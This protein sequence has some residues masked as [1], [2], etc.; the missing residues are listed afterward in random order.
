[1][2][3]EDV[4]GDLSGVYLKRGDFDNGDLSFTIASVD[5]VT[6]EARNGKPPEQKWALT[7]A[8]KPVRKFSLNKTNLELM[9]KG[10]GKKTGGWVGKAIELFLD[11]SVTYGGRL[12]GGIR[13]RLPKRRPA[14]VVTDVVSDKEIGF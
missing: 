7:F 5:K 11:E 10:Y 3:D 1:M 14:P 12:V 6:F 9:A 2:Q 4:T 13:I 8:S